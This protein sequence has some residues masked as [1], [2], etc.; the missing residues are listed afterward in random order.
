MDIIKT[1]CPKC[2]SP[3]EF[4]KDFDNVICAKCGAAFQVRAYKDAINLSPKD[5]ITWQST[6]TD[7]N[8]A[9]ALAVVESRLAEL[10]ELISEAGAEVEVLKSKELSVPLQTGCSFF[11]LFMLVIIVITAFMPLGRKYFGNW[12]FY[13]A[14]ALVILLGLQRIRRKQTSPAQIEQF[15]AERL[16]IEAGLAQL[17]AERDHVRDLKARITSFDSEKIDR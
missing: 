3:L 11:G 9:E 4:P 5:Q 12:L 15:R 13:L 6:S 8:E 7:M 10:D 14:I 17:E 1:N 2:T 16:N